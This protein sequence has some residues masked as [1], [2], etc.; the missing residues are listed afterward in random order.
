[1]VC[2][3]FRAQQSMSGPIE[4]QTWPIPNSKNKW[5]NLCLF[6]DVFNAQSVKENLRDLTLEAAILDCKCTCAF[7]GSCVSGAPRGPLHHL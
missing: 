6:R 1:M 7:G 4:R 3:R 2:D 5:I